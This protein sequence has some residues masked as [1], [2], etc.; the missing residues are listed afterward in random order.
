LNV[1]PVLPLAVTVIDPPEP[2]DT[3]SV[4][5]AVTTIFLPAHASVGGGT[6]GVGELSPLLQDWMRKV[7][8]VSNRTRINR[9]FFMLSFPTETE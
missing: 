3:A 7:A 8:E 1:K 9:N 6:G 2:H 4:A 5:D